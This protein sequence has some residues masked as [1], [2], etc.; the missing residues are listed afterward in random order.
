M[1]YTAIADRALETLFVVG[2][3][4]PTRHE[5]ADAYPFIEHATDYIERKIWL[6]RVLA[7]RQAHQQGAKR[8]VDKPRRAFRDTPTPFEGF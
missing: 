8:P 6:Q 5:L 1:H 3:P 2:R 4:A 7:W